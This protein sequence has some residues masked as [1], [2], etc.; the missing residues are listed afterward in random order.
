MTTK[1]KLSLLRNEMKA[2]GLDAFVVFN[3]DPHMSEYFTPYWE[4]R[5]WITSFDSSAG[6]SLLSTGQ[7][8]AYRYRGGFLYRRY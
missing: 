4:E 2:N 7:K 6:W 3:A 1:E 8:S 5:K